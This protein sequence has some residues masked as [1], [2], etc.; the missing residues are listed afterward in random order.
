MT[1]DNDSTSHFTS[2]A[3]MPLFVK[4][5]HPDA[6]VPTY[7]TD[8]S[9]CFDLYAIDDGRMHP[10]DA[11]A[12]TYRTGLAFEVPNGWAME[13]F[14]RSGHGFNNAIRLSNCVGIIDSD[15]RGEVQVALRFDGSYAY[16]SMKLRAGDRI[17]QAKLVRAPRVQFRV[18]EELSTTTRGLGGFGSTGN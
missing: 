11:H 1:A 3:H 10:A 17:A 13:I 5:L 6:I 18:V 16:R 7:A 4:K 15:Y 2:L 8:G 9:A 14:S 12:A